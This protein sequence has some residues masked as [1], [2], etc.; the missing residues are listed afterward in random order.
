M[1]GIEVLP[2]RVCD[3]G[4]RDHFLH[5]F[6]AENRILCD[7]AVC[8]LVLPILFPVQHAWPV[9]KSC[10]SL[11]RVRFMHSWD[12]CVC[13]NDVQSEMFSVIWW[14]VVFSD[15]WLE[16]QGWY[17]G[18]KTCW[19][20][21]PSYASLWWRM[22]LECVQHARLCSMLGFSTYFVMICVPSCCVR[23]TRWCSVRIVIC[24][25]MKFM[26]LDVHQHAVMLCVFKLWTWMN[27]DEMRQRLPEH[28]RYVLW[29]LISITIPH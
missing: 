17:S 27:I 4:M 26:F 20:H 19:V 22:I 23:H 8:C 1:P 5:C 10:A 21:V 9:L 18:M 28:W 3:F 7:L 16:H 13:A 15:T 11:C 6:S 24:T 12:P 2:F 25:L 29:S 14:Y